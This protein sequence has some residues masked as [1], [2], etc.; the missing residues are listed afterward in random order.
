MDKL[1]LS[2]H[3]AL[4]WHNIDIGINNLQAG[5]ENMEV[6]IAKDYDTL[7]K[8]AAII[9]AGQVIGQPSS[10]LGLATGSSPVETYKNLAVFYREGIVDFSRVTAFNLDEY[11]GVAPDNPCSY[12]WFME[13]NLFKYINIL[14][15]NT[16]I[17]DGLAKD[18]ATECR[19]YEEKIHRAGGID[20]QLLGIGG[21]GHIGFNEPGTNFQSATHLV[22]LNQETIE[23]NSRFFDSPD[24]V[25]RQALSM[26]IKSIMAARKIILLASGRAKAKAVYE[27][28]LGPITPQH[29]ASVLQLH[30]QVVVIVD[31]EAASLLG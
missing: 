9:I 10:V 24:Q 23:A 28:V 2:L 11:Y 13:D 5:D 27:M 14:P 17:P 21:N 30:P 1:D 31:K 12:R 22:E 26:G 18:T 4:E 19:E 3:T 29:P 15:E 16:H 6:I 20:L 8:Q 25:P 7:S